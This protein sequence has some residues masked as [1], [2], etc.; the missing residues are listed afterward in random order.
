M[1]YELV[2]ITE[3]ATELFVYEVGVEEKYQRHGI[4]RALVE[5]AREL[6]RTR[7]LNALY[8]PAMAGDARAVAFY[9]ARGLKREQVAWFS[10]E[11]GEPPVEFNSPPA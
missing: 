5:A 10:K 7:G 2:M 3:K 11:F 1:G 9:A 6:R 8:I 4:G